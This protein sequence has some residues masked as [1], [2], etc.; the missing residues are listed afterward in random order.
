MD[1]K[2]SLLEARVYLS[3]TP[4]H[5]AVLVW[6]SQSALKTLR[7]IGAKIEKVILEGEIPL[8]TPICNQNDGLVLHLLRSGEK[9]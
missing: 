8:Q 6:R 7:M 4:F 1:E 9:P 3:Y 2:E 5:K